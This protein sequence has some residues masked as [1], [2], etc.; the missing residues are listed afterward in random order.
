VTGRDFAATYGPWAV[1][2]GGS[3]GLG[4]AFAEEIARRG[5][6]LVLVARRREPLERTASLLRRDHAAEVVTVAT[7]LASPGA[8]A[9]M[10]SVTRDRPVGLLVT[11]AAQ[12]PAGPFASAAEAEMAAAIDLNCRAAMLLARMFLP[13]MAR[14]GQGGLILMSSLAGLQGV[15][16][17]AVYSATKAFLICLGEALWAEMRGTGVD[18]LTCCPG[19]VTTPNYSRAARGAAVGA[20][21]PAVVASEALDGLGH[22]FRVVPGRLNRLSAI[23]L[24]RIFPK[25]IAISVF[26]RATLSALHEASTSVAGPPSSAG[27]GPHHDDRPVA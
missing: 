9:V 10:R 4:A 8:A 22:G 26:E 6:G 13:L 17:L 1:V 11:N 5:V 3:E 25:R 19:A 24:Q 7:D 21:P 23:V 14:R 18:V 16:N 12:A 20:Q 15:P 2:A 27:R